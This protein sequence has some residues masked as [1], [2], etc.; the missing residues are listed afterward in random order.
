M[1]QPDILKMCPVPKLPRVPLPSLI[2][3]SGGL[4]SAQAPSLPPTEP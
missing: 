4:T 3:R 1:Q 2:S